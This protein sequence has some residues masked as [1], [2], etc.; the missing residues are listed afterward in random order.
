MF[1]AIQG[2]WDARD[3][4]ALA[5]LVGDDLHGRVAPAPERLRPQ[6][7]A[8][9]RAR[10]HR[11]RGPLRRDDQP[12]ARRGGPRRRAHRRAARGLRRG[13]RRDARAGDRRHRHGHRPAR[14]LDARQA[15]R[16]L[17]PHVDRAGRRGRPSPRRPARHLAVGRRARC[18]TSR[19]SRAPS[20]TPRCPASRPPSS[21]DVD[22]AADARAQALDLSLADARFAPDVLAAAARRAAESWADAVDGDDAPLAAV[23]TADAIDALLYGGDHSHD[24]RL[25]VRGPRIDGVAIERLDA[26]PEPPRMTLAVQRARPP[27]R[28]GPRHRRRAVGQQGAGD[29][30]HRALDDGARRHRRDA[31]AARRRRRLS[32]PAALDNVAGGGV[33]LWSCERP[34]DTLGWRHRAD[35]RPVTEEVPLVARGDSRFVD[36]RRGGPVR[37]PGH[38]P[39]RARQALRRRRRR[40]PRRPRDRARRV[41][42]DARARPGSGK[43]TT[44]RMIAGFDAPD[45]GPRRARRRGRRAAP[46]VRARRQHRLPGLRAVP[47]HE[48]AATTSRTG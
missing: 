2:A 21:I 5:S 25:V 30:L 41:L 46:A 38:P 42:H 11:A 17:D 34:R 40:R 37:R 47:A 19:S 26:T 36:R 7:L 23:A 3:E 32:P 29:R 24:S 16:P 4:H 48:R 12:R 13:G 45:A 9:P 43:T 1:H 22:L 44:L 33:P 31:V 14:V 10:H 6:G 28:R 20:P 15:R 27:L 8:Q 35:D 39:R 18:A